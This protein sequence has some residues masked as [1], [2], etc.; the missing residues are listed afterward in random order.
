MS[1]PEAT[2]NYR[3]H[4]MGYACR[5]CGRAAN[6]GKAIRHSSLCDIAPREDVYPAWPG[7]ELLVR[8]DEALAAGDPSAQSDVE[9]IHGLHD[10][11]PNRVTVCSRGGLGPYVV[12]SFER[13][14][15]TYCPGQWVSIAAARRASAIE[16]H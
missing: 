6:V 4:P 16:T 2:A 13:G 3:K 1:R 8:A 15:W 14:R 9:T 7:A 10:Q 5:D 12:Q 11:T